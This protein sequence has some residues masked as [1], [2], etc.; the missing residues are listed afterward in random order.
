MT[1]SCVEDKVLW[2]ESRCR[3]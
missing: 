2:V 3:L 1:S